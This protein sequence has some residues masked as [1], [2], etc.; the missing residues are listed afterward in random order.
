MNPSYGPYHGGYWD[1]DD[2]IKA[3]EYSTI[4]GRF[5]ADIKTRNGP[6]KY[7]YTPKTNY[8]ARPG[9]E[10]KGL[11]RISFKILDQK[12]RRLFGPLGYCKFPCIF[13]HIT[14]A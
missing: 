2:M 10:S 14:A 5:L 7:F 11:P 8:K 4:L 9:Q 6:E 13:V 12:G 3:R 1:Y